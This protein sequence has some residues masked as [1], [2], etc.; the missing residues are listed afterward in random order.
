M[1]N[2]I[3]PRLILASISAG[4]ILAGGALF[5]TGVS[6][7]D[8]YV[9]PECDAGAVSSN[10]HEDWFDQNGN[11]LTN[12]WVVT[13]YYPSADTATPKVVKQGSGS[14]KYLNSKYSL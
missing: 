3:R 1:K 11:G 12:D 10:Y 8:T 2:V 13:C 14:G 9:S 4:A 5:G 7:A 6:S